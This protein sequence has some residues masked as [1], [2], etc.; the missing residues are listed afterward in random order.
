[1]QPELL[2]PVGDLDMCYAAVHNG[3]NAVYVGVPGWNARG[4]TLDF[5][6]EDLG[7]LGEF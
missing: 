2:A 5:S 4:R 1:M 6:Y 7:A 3:A